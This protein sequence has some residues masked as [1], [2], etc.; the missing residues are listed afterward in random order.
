MIGAASKHG[1]ARY[2]KGRPQSILTH[3]DGRATL[4]RLLPRAQ[5]A[6]A[7]TIKHYTMCYGQTPGLAAVNAFTQ[8]ENYSIINIYSSAVKPRSYLNEAT[9]ANLREDP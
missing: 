5:D 7:R 9:D 3:S 1:R 2:I 8:K 4:F 6:V